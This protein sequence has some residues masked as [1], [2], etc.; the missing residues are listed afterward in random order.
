MRQL[1]FHFGNKKQAVKFA[2]SYCILSKI[3]ME[4]SLF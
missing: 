4:Y 3:E 2:G 1:F